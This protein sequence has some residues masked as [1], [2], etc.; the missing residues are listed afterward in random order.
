VTESLPPRDATEM[1]RAE[2]EGG[3]TNG[4]TP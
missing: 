4:G 2:P 1:R 3:H